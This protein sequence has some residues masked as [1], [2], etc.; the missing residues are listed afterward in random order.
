MCYG[1]I[2]GIV[3][4][5]VN[6]PTQ[7]AAAY[8]QAVAHNMAIRLNANQLRRNAELAEMQAKEAIS[9]GQEQRG[10]WRRGVR[11]VL[12]AQ[13]AAAAHAGVLVGAGSVGQV[14]SATRLK[15]AIGED[16]IRVN[17]YRESWY[18]RMM[19]LQY[20]TQAEMLRATKI[21]PHY[22]AYQAAMGSAR[23]SAS[24]IAGSTMRSY[25]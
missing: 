11:E 6:A 17:A 10:D 12:G 5:V 23:G 25:Y 8:E 18:L 24:N 15:G 22:A 7:G 9:R 13:K 1:L 4:G 14:E 16:R 2:G 20:R 21:R 3:Q 19:A